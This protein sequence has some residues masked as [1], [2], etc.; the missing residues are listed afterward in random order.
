MRLLIIPI[1]ALVLASLAC[2][3]AG[4]PIVFTSNI[5]GNREIFSLDPEK[6]EL[7]NLTKSS[8]SE[9]SPSLS[10]DG[11]HLAFLAGDDEHNILEVIALNKETA[12]RTAVSKF[13]GTHRDHRWS[14][15]GDRLAY[16][17]QNG[18]DPS[19]H[20]ADYDGSASMELTTIV[21]HEVGGWS[22]DG[23][24]VV[25]TVREGPGRGIYVRNPTAST[26]SD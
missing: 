19:T 4:S 9:Y 7:V 11:S 16:L 17:V 2:S 15:A 22:Y 10:P 3:S 14:P 18:G 13:D 25:F 6:A 23:S 20:V 5:D 8:G 24:S 26:R 21:A 12:D 1:M